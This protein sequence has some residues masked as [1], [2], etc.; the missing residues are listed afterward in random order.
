MA[1]KKVLEDRLQEVINR[2][3][4]MAIIPKC[5][6]FQTLSADIQITA[7][8]RGLLKEAEEYAYTMLRPYIF[9]YTVSIT[10]EKG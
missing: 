8:D 9:D 6:A 10:K 4:K 3:C 5:D 7:N 2:G 1:L